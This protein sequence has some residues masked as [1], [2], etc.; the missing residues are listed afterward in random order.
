MCRIQVIPEFT[1]ATRKQE[2]VKEALCYARD[3]DIVGKCKHFRVDKDTFSLREV[4]IDK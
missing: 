3:D 4:I 1:V 2:L